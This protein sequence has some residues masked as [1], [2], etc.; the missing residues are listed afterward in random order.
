VKWPYSSINYKYEGRSNGKIGCLVMN[1]I[2][3]SSRAQVPRVNLTSSTLSIMHNGKE[4]MQW[5]S[6]A[7]DEKPE[8]DFR[9]TVIVFF[10]KY[11]LPSNICQG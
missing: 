2:L 4:I 8:E 11:S 9:L 7:A 3:T 10:F 6:T 1:N 5:L